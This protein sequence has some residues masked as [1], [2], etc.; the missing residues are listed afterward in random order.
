MHIIML[1]LYLTQIIMSQRSEVKY[2][3]QLNEV[4]HIQAL[5]R[6]PILESSSV[7][8][9]WLRGQRDVNVSGSMESSALL[10]APVCSGILHYGIRSIADDLE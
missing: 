6:W 8:V 4:L 9:S 1:G 10:H 5:F 7:L 3:L 2:L